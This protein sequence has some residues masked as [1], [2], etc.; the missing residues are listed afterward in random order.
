LFCDRYRK[1]SDLPERLPVFPLRGAILL[2]RVQLPLNVFEP[3]YLAMVD[4]IL[5][6]DRL[7]GLVQPQSRL[8]GS[9]GSIDEEDL[10]AE[11]PRDRSWPLRDTGCIG[12]ITSFSEQEDGRVFISLTGIAR[13]NIVAEDDVSKPYRVCRISTHAFADDLSNDRGEGEVD[14]ERL[15]RLLRAYLEAHELEADWRSIQQSSTELLVNTLAIHSPFGAEEKQALLEAADLKTRSEILMA[16][17]EM[18][19]ATGSDGNPG[20]PLQ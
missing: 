4:D 14:R 20:G 18:D 11:S 2:P 15:L 8:S 17:A 19:L 10:E 1:L 7:I 3:R 9:G 12:R 5:G 16:L 6:G 13:F